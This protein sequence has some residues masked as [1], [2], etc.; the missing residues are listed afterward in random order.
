M[1]EFI[2]QHQF[3]T[4]ALLLLV[5]LVLA[6][7]AAGYKVHPGALNATD[8][9]AYDT[10]LIAETTIDQARTD[11]QNGQLPS[12]AKDALNKLIE[13][14]TIARESWLTYRGVL[15]TNVPPDEYIQQLAKNLTDLTD[16]IRA[17]KEV[18]R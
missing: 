11:Y 9:A 6:G 8:S 14:Y 3:L 10:L 16:A 15:A 5:P 18:K 12:D 1:I 7:C 2:T 13:A 4:F 17:I